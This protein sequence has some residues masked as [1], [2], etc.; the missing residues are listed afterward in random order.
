L[1]FT[2]IVYKD[3]EK[4][5]SEKAL[6]A[7]LTAAQKGGHRGGKQGNGFK[8]RGA[9]RFNQRGKSAGRGGKKTFGQNRGNWQKQR[10]GKKSGRG[11]KTG[12]RSVGSA[13][14]KE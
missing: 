13:E 7:A 10:D 1:V 4:F 8:P 12:K 14:H 6:A 5:Q 11:G 2:G 3:P 9:G